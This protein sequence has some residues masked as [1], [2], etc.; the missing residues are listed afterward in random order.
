M[1]H[2][3]EDPGIGSHLSPGASN[4]AGSQTGLPKRKREWVQSGWNEKQII[5]QKTKQKKVPRKETHI[6]KKN[7]MIYKGFPLGRC[8]VFLNRI[9]FSECLLP[10]HDMVTAISWH[11]FMQNFHPGL[12]DQSPSISSSFFSSSSSSS[13]SSFSSSSSS[14]TTTTT[15]SY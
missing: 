5:Y 6:R 15:T 11:V 8:I 3:T 10:E 2:R 9:W 4:T 13:S 1:L 14:T 7:M 12:L